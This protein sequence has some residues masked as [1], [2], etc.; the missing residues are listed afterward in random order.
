MR[1]ASIA[2]FLLALFAA[3]AAEAR[4][5]LPDPS[6]RSAGLD[7]AYLARA[8][9]Y[10]AT[11]WNPANLALPD[12]PGWSVGLPGGNAFLANNSL[13]YGRIESLYGNFLDR[14]AKSRLLA[15]I[16][17]GDPNRPFELA[18]EAGANVVGLSLGPFAIAIGS[19]GT[20][21]GRLSADALELLLFGNAGESGTGKDFNLQG[22]S[23]VAWWTS[24]VALSYGHAIT[25]PALDWIGMKFAA[26]ATVHY[27][28]AHSFA[29]IDDRGTQLTT[30]PLAASVGAELV[31][32]TDAWSGSGWSVDLG[33]AMKWGP[34]SVGL[35]ARNLLRNMA[36]DPNGTELTLYRASADFDSTSSVKETRP[37]AELAPEEQD[38]VRQLLQDADFPTAIRLGGSYQAARRLTLSADYEEVIGGT[39][40]TGWDRTFALGA[41]VRPLGFLPLR[42]GVGTDFSDIS[43]A[44]GLGI[45]GGPVHFDLSAVRAGLPGGDGLRIALSLGIWPDR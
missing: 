29:R 43:Y 13:G 33:T 7:F 4:A 14:Q 20:A 17:K 28:I 22:S 19:S 42:G 25:I 40:R 15:D 36:W 2:T 18:A 34:W 12:R 5:Q 30:D 39:L 24:D 9:G 23:G 6:A 26:G 41:E 1:H 31:N 32:T 8:R 16:R 37:F 3:S 35:A 21:V 11:F 27:T 38:S 45:Y 10:E 44:A